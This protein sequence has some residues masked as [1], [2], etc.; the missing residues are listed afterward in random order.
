MSRLPFESEYLYGLHDPGGEHLM[1]A[2]DRKGWILFTEAVGTDPSLHQGNPNYQA[3][4][5]GGFGIIVRLNN[6]YYNAGTLPHSSQYENFARC[7]ANFVAN[8]PGGHIWVI[9]NETNMAAER[10]GVE[11]SGWRGSETDSAR[12]FRDQLSVFSASSRG[13]GDI[14]NPGETITPE[15]Y[16][17]CYTLCRKAIRAVPG[18]GNDLILTG[19]VAPWNINSGD[20]IDYFRRIHE[21]LGPSRCDGISLHTYTHGVGA[22]LVLSDEKMQ[23]HPDRH[24]HFRAYQDFMQAVPNNMRHLPVYIT[25]MDQDDAWS[26]ERDQNWV[27]RAYGELDHWNQ[28]PGHQQIRAAVLYRWPRLG[29]HKWWIAGNDGVTNDFKKSMEHGYRWNPDVVPA[30]TPVTPTFSQGQQ[31]VVVSKVNLRKTAGYQGKPADDVKE[32]LAPGTHVTILALS[33]PLDGLLWWH[34]RVTLADGQPVEGWLAQ[35]TPGGKVL[36]TGS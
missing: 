28:Q 4:S 30:P 7:C 15:L 10:P 9:G 20:W 24:Y 17:R 16:V 13:S 12:D 21:I 5:D 36:L 8:S 14:V 18:H 6:G 1:A 33:Q 23:S 22:N 3:L 19:A 35:I 26:T 29:D 25:E 2:A 31:V 34:V 27:Q 32:Q 11:I